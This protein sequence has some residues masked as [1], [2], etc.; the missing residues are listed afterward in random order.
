MSFC[1]DLPTSFHRLISVQLSSIMPKVEYP[2]RK[3]K[4]DYD[5]EIYIRPGRKIVCDDNCECSLMHASALDG[6]WGV[7]LNELV[8]LSSGRAELRELQPRGFWNVVAAHGVNTDDLV[9]SV[10]DMKLYVGAHVMETQWKLF[11]AMSD[12]GNNAE[13]HPLMD[14][15]VVRSSTASS[16][17]PVTRMHDDASIVVSNILA[18]G[19]SKVLQLDETTEDLIVDEAAEGD[20]VPQVPETEQ[21]STFTVDMTGK[22]H[23]PYESGL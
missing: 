21:S 6:G 7:T 14:Y 12:M 2:N 10:T 17:I 23:E 11:S 5:D 20:T 18:E 8:A 16:G 15:I 4:P 13:H 19:Y 1:S 3:Y 22:R 9:Y